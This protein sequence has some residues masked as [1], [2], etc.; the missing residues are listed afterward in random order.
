MSQGFMNVFVS[1]SGRNIP[2]V[3]FP[4]FVIYMYVLLFACMCST[5][6]Q[7]MQRPKLYIK[8]PG[9]GVASD[10]ELPIVD[11]GSKWEIFTKSSKFF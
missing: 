1:S 3:F 7:W 11:V 10:Y 5:D 8:C 2:Y 9:T 4:Y 6:T